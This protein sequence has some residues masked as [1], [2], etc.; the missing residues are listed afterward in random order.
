M[1]HQERPVEEGEE[2]LDEQ[3]KRHQDQPERSSD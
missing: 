2:V 3:S 1:T